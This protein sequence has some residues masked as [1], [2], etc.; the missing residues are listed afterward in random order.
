MNIK[1]DIFEVERLYLNSMPPFFTI[2]SRIVYKPSL[3]QVPVFQTCFFP[4]GSWVPC[5]SYHSSQDRHLSSPPSC[6]TFHAIA[7][8]PNLYISFLHNDP[9]PLKILSQS[10]NDG[11][12][13]PRCPPTRTKESK[14]SNTV[15]TNQMLSLFLQPPAAR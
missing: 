8:A 5:I 2:C 4:A 15:H 13:N 12:T 9:F 6:R 14:N 7:N 11:N 3:F 1:H 10:I